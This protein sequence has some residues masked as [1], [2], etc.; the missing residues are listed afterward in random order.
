M[1]PFDGRFSFTPRMLQAHLGGTQE[2]YEANEE[3]E[4]VRAS[5]FLFS[6]LKC[7]LCNN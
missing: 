4:D 6:S 1:Y 7:F 2:D 5:L 3:E